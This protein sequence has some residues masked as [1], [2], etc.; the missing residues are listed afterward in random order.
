M[1]DC[2]NGRF[3]PLRPIAELLLFCLQIVSCHPLHKVFPCKRQT[4]LWDSHI[5]TPAPK[6]KGGILFYP[7]PS[8]RPSVRPSFRPSVVPSHFCVTHISGT[9]QHRTLKFCTLLY[10]CMMYRGIDFQIHRTYTSC[11]PAT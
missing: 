4:F 1:P 10:I 8:F 3:S 6:E 5:Y 11:L 2:L 9:I 7:C